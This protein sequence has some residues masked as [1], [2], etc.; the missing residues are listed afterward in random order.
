M[1]AAIIA[2]LSSANMDAPSW[3]R[4]LA[5]QTSAVNACFSLAMAASLRR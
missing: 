2:R 4:V 5:R 1:A 3:M